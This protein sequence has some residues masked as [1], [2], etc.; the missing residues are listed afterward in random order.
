M[1]YILG[2]LIE[3]YGT[4]YSKNEPA[5]KDTSIKKMNHG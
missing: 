1:N 5:G 3:T 2:E 4:L